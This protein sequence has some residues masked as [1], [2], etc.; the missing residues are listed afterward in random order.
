[1]IDALDRRDFIAGLAGG[2]LRRF[3]AAGRRNRGDQK[4]RAVQ[5]LMS[6]ERKTRDSIE[7]TQQ[8]REKL[9]DLLVEMY[10][11]YHFERETGEEALKILTLEQRQ[12][13]ADDVDRQGS[14]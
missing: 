13:L 2:I 4:R 14:L 8:Q 1:M 11:P 9:L 6:P 7:A 3:L 10:D 5:A 12:K